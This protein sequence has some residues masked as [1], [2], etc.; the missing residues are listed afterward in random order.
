MIKH[1][2]KRNPSVKKKLQAAVQPLNPVSL[3]SAASGSA[4]GFV[5]LRMSQSI[6]PPSR[7]ISSFGSE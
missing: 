4:P 7:L 5:P 1:R 2:I 6:L 3:W